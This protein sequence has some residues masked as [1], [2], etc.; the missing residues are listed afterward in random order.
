MQN[1]PVDLS[2]RIST[3]YN[4]FPFV[5]EGF[6]LLPDPCRFVGRDGQGVFVKIFRWAWALARSPKPVEAEE[7]SGIGVKHG[8]AQPVQIFGFAGFIR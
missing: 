1:L 7:F 5:H 4:P 6:S 3:R 8:N 2:L